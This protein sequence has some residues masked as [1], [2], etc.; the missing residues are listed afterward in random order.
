[1]AA[2]AWSVIPPTLAAAA[3]LMSACA[4]AGRPA[5]CDDLQRVVIRVRPGS[6]PGFSWEPPCAVGNVSVGG[7]REV[8]WEIETRDSANLILPPILYGST[9]PGV[10]ELISA[11]LAKSDVLYTISVSRFVLTKERG[12]VLVVVGQVKFGFD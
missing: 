1:V 2:R 4:L 6:M 11:A 7:A 10:R 5:D 8:T 12:R 3:V 9:R